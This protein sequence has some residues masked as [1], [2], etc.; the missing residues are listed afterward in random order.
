VSHPSTESCSPDSGKNEWF[1]KIEFNHWSFHNN[2]KC[3]PH[4]SSKRASDLSLSEDSDEARNRER[5]VAK[6]LKLNSSHNGWRTLKFADVILPGFFFQF[7]DKIAKNRESDSRLNPG[8]NSGER[9]M[10]LKQ[11]AFGNRN[12][13]RFFGM[14]ENDR[15]YRRVK[16]PDSNKVAGQSWMWRLWRLVAVWIEYCEWDVH[17]SLQPGH[18]DSFSSD[19][20]SRAFRSLYWHHDWSRFQLNIVSETFISFIDLI[21]SILSFPVNYQEIPD[22][23]SDTMISRG[24]CLPLLFHFSRKRLNAS[25]LRFVILRKSSALLN[26]DRLSSLTQFSKIVLNQGR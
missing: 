25:T 13:E 2:L 3:K 22:Q 11:T 10:T 21:G 14:D 4:K 8:K 19:Q 16:W 9:W 18:D 17:V 26:F 12:C 24:F 20:L 6:S 5:F 1:C 7:R 15:S 23:E